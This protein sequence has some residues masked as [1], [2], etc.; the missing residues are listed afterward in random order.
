MKV[1]ASAVLAAG[2]LGAGTADATIY[3]A[4]INTFD[5]ITDLDSVI[6][7]SDYEGV[8]FEGSGLIAFDIV[9]ADEIDGTPVDRTGGDVGFTYSYSFSLLDFDEVVFGSLNTTV[10]IGGAALSPDGNVATFTYQPAT[11]LSNLTRLGSVSFLPD[12]LGATPH[13]DVADVVLAPVENVTVWDASV[14]DTVLSMPVDL[15]DVPVPAGAAL[16]PAAL[17]GLG[18]LRRRR[19]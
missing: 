5:P 2:L 16:L 9:F 11:N 7:M 3:L 6:P 13:D 1:L 17:L 15:Q 4:H 14:G 19:G 18:A 8:T 10:F 12:V